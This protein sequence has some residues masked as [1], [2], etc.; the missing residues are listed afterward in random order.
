MR[1]SMSRI[2]WHQ[3]DLF[4]GDRDGGNCIIANAMCVIFD[5]MANNYEYGCPLPDRRLKLLSSCCC[6]TSSVSLTHSL[7]LVVPSG[8]SHRQLRP[9]QMQRILYVKYMHLLLSPESRLSTHD[10][11]LKASCFM[12]PAPVP[13][14]LASRWISPE[15]CV[16]L[17]FRRRKTSE[18]LSM[19]TLTF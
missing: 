13:E 3:C 6:W 9:T 16:G 14:A 1:T 7:I 18:V 4:L 10:T 15:L 2:V 8:I 12:H 19:R 17:R 5:N 11:I